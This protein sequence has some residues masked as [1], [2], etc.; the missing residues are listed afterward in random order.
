MEHTIKQVEEQMEWTIKLVET[1]TNK[2]N[3]GSNKFN[4]VKTGGNWIKKFQLRIKQVEQR[5]KYVETG[6]NGNNRH[7][8]IETEEQTGLNRWNRRTNRWKQD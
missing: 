8:Q 4:K 2:W 6:L 1:G 3:R 5:S 7:K